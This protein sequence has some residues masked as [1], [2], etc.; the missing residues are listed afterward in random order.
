MCRAKG[1]LKA[2]M[3]GGAAMFSLAA[4]DPQA[5]IGLRNIQKAKEFLRKEDVRLIVQDT[6]DNYGRRV[7]FHLNTGELHVTSLRYGTRKYS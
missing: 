6:G 1:R 3:V 7:A 5:N 2:Y 4:D